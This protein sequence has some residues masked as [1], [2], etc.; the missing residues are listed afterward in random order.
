MSTEENKAKVRRVIEEAWNKGDLA[1]VDE[2]LAPNYVFH[3]P[4]NDFKGP[5]GLKQAVTM[6]RNALPDLHVA[7]E[8]M[9]A[10]GDKVACRYTYRGTLKGELMG[11]APTGK[12]FIVTGAA[13]MH[14][15]GGKEVEAFNF[16]DQLS[17]SQ[18]LGV[19]PP[20]SPVGK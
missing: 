18:Q 8:D 11:I 3:V 20:V 6:Y 5:E 12:Q 13:F 2:L 4:G 16:F 10:E 15:V 9:F 14:F 19:A 17:M 7:I 1:V